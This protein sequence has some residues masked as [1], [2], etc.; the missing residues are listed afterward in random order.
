[1]RL[2]FVQVAM[3]L[4]EQ[5]A[6]DV[7]ATLDCD[8]AKIG[9]G[10]LKAIIWALG[11]CPDDAPPSSNAVIEGKSAAK[12]IARAAGH[13]GDPEAFVDACSAARP[14]ILERV[15]GGIRFRGFDRYDDAWR[16]A[17]SRSVKAKHAAEHRWGTKRA[18]SE[19][20]PSIDHALPQGCSSD[21]PGCLDP[22]PEP[23]PYPESK[24]PPP[25]SSAGRPSAEV[26]VGKDFW[27]DGDCY[28][29]TT[30]GAWELI[31]RIRQ[32]NRLPRELSRPKGFRDWAPRALKESGMSGICDT[33]IR[34]VGD[35]KIEAKG[36][37]TAV[38]IG[39]VWEARKP[40]AKGAA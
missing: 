8:E 9:W 19:H 39:G 5:V 36:H 16:N 40:V 6:P 29:A 21:A 23:D 14:S 26:V 17:R 3:E 25:T 27:V 12:L 30:D 1:M 31:Q 28:P 2:P 32:E 10:I 34:F 18:S 38:F 22:Y 24:P 37:P 11:R 7:A 15:D 20:P 4:V 35:N 13:L 33:H